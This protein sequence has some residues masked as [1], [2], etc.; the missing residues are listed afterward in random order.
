MAPQI[1][2]QV[3]RDGK[4][5]ATKTVNGRP[6]L[7]GND[8]TN[9]LVVEGTSRHQ[10][11][12]WSEDGTVWIKNLGDAN[13]LRLDGNKI[14]AAAAISSEKKVQI[15]DSLALT[16]RPADIPATPD[17]HPY[18]LTVDMQATTGPEATIED[19]RTGKTCII[20]S[21][22][23]V[24][25]LYLLA[26]EISTSSDKDLKERGWCQDQ[27]IACG[28][29]GRNWQKQIK[30]HLHVLVHRIRKEIKTAG[31]DPW[32]IEKKR[33]HTRALIQEAVIK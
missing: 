12:L 7:I 30:S 4:V 33:C 11:L 1:E 9:D 15:T 3:R 19:L 5:L 20:R 21:N 22:N 6:V 29:W 17:V 2:V 8:P 32:C 16:F 13:D 26:K 31:L 28:V 24:S 18:R 14:D 25:V 23:R 10:A 27:S